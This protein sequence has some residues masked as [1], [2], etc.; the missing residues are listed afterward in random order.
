MRSILLPLALIA[1]A[2]ASAPPDARTSDVEGRGP[3]AP[4]RMSKDVLPAGL[5]FRDGYLGAA[6]SSHQRPAYAVLAGIYPSPELA[7]PM[8]AQLRQRADLAPGYPMVVHTDELGLEA[9]DEGVAVVVA[10]LAGEQAAQSWVE[11]NDRK[12]WP[13]KAL[14]TAEEA[15]ERA[16]H[17]D[18]RRVVVRVSPDAPA[19]GHDPALITAAEEAMWEG[20]GADPLEVRPPTRCIIPPDA[21]FVVAQEDLYRG[22]YRWVSVTCEDGQPAAVAAQETLLHTLFL[23]GPQG[24][25]ER[26]QVSGVA[27]DSPSFRRV[28]VSATGE[29]REV[30][31]RLASGCAR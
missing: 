3:D 23:P 17:H 21:L 9:P 22:D 4:V 2:C 1:S 18:A 28:A 11:G 24:A 19:L 15:R 12:G 16:S 25:Y 7:A 30:A 13:I 26:V 27:C 29:V 10:M 20:A 8:I 14:L 5:Y 6:A 31:M